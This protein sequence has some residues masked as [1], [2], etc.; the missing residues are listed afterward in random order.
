MYQNDFKT[1]QL[2][3]SRF[4]LAIGPLIL[5]TRANKVSTCWNSELVL[6][7]SEFQTLY[8]LARC[9]DIKVSFDELYR[10]IW[11]DT[12]S[13][14]KIQDAKECIDKL[15]RK[16]K[17]FGNGFVWIDEINNNYVF[18]TRW[19]HNKNNWVNQNNE[20][21]KLSADDYMISSHR[22]KLSFR[23]IAV[24]ASSLAA[25]FI[26]S[27]LAINTIAPRDFNNTTFINDPQTPLGQAINTEE[28]CEHC[29]NVVYCNSYK[30]CLDCNEE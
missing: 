26:L 8:I 19:G 21:A 11:E 4:K 27:I 24:L 29:E 22:G 13:T 5:D 17:T 20:F 30:Y 15:I 10:S 6:S 23:T 28:T 2:Y 16:L 7:D 18:R 25:C 3:T 14:N 9:E 12:K 1:E